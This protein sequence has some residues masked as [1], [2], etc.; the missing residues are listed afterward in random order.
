MAM[1]EETETE[2]IAEYDQMQQEKYE[3]LVRMQYEE[4]EREKAEWLEKELR[5]EEE[6]KRNEEIYIRKGDEKSANVLWKNIFFPS[7]FLFRFNLNRSLVAFT[8]TAL[9]MS[10]GIGGISYVNKGL[11]LKSK[12]LGVSQDGYSNISAA[13]ND[14]SHQNFESSSQ[15]FSQ[16]HLH[17]SEGTKELENMGG[18]ILDATRFIPFA[19]KISSGKNAVEAG[20]HFSA[21]GQSINE[22]IKL[23]AEII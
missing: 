7:R 16:A 5:A 6:N 9:A 14:L 1:Q 13:I 3:E 2:R 19:S 12:V 17:F 21:A 20:K 15:Q 8:L 11:S 18:L 22:V 10:L 4:L 23:L